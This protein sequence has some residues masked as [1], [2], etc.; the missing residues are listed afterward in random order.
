MK[1]NIS[2]ILRSYIDAA[3]PIIYINHFDFTEIDEIITS[4]AEGANCIEYNNALG[5]I[6]F[7]TRS[8]MEE[9]D[10]EQ[11]LKLT[12]DDGFESE[13]FLILKDIN[14]ELKNP[15]VIALLKRISENIVNTDDYSATIFIISSQ[16]VIP[17]ELEHFITVFDVPM[18]SQQDILDIIQKFIKEYMIIVEEEIVDDLALS[19]K[20]LTEFQINQILNLAFTDGGCITREDKALI[21]K[22][23]ERFLK[24][25]I[26][27]K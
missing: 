20:G 23:K 19:F 7:K 26:C 11:F 8:P 9:C 24:N 21:L 5:M 3:N 25:L 27:L 2:N 13:T 17:K 4:I 6:D 18:P 10:L 12:M 22:E 15:K 16:V 1:E 14:E